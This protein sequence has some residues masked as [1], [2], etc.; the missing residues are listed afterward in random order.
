MSAIREGFCE[1]LDP[2]RSTQKPYQNESSL[3][4]SGASRGDAG[5]SERIRQCS[6][7]NLRITQ[8]LSRQATL[9]VE[10]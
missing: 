1:P 3:H 10:L 6:C 5:A 4:V 8:T 7:V 9:R 2:Q